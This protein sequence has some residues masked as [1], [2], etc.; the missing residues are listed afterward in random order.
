MAEISNRK[1]VSEEKT[2][3]EVFIPI[4]Q[5]NPKED[6]LPVTVNGKT[7]LVKRGMSVPVPD[8]VYEVLKFKRITLR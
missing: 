5:S 2:M 1:N 6:T 7:Y 8:E 4:D 3:K